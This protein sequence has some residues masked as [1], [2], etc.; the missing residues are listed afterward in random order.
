MSHWMLDLIREPWPWY[1]AGPLIGLMVPLLRF[2]TG[3]AFGISSSL[4]HLCAA[5]GRSRSSYLCYDWRATGGWNLVFALGVVIGASLATHFLGGAWSVDV[6]EGTREQLATLGVS[7][8]GLVPDELY[9]LTSL[10]SLLTL[11]GG[12]FLVGFGARYAG[13]C[14]SGHAITGLADLQPASLI[15]VLGFFG[16]GLLATHWLLPTLIGG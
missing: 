5:T 16:G 6:T 1:V 11:L 2:T 12:G 10:K 7:V 14:T 8:H 13:G 15:A 3:K 9:G 4:R